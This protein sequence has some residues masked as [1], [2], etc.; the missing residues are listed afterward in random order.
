MTGRVTL[1]WAAGDADGNTL[2]YDVLISRDAGRTFQPLKGEL[3]IRSTQIDTDALGGGSVIFRVVATDGVLT[4][5]SDSPTYSLAAKPPSVQLLTAAGRVKLV[6][7]QNINLIGQARDLQ[8][9][10]VADSGL[11]WTDQKGVVRGRG[12]TL[13]LTQL[14]AGT[15]RMTLTATNSAGLSASASVELVVDDRVEPSGATLDV[16]PGQVRWVV[17]PGAGPQ[18]AR[19]VLGNVGTGSLQWTASTTADWLTLTPAAGSAPETV[20]LTGNPVGLQPGESRTTTLSIRTRDG[21]QTLAVPVSL[22]AEG[23]R[24]EGP[25][26]TITPVP[27]VVG[28]GT[29]DSCTPAALETTLAAASD[30]GKA[31]ITFN[32]GDAPHTLTLPRTLTI[33]SNMIVDGAN[34]ITLNGNGLVRHF[35]LCRPTSNGAD[36]VELELAGLT[37]VNGRSQP[38]RAGG[39]ITNYGCRLTVSH[40]RFVS[41]TAVA[42]AGAINN[43]FD[44]TTTIVESAFIDNRA[45]TT[46]GAIVAREGQLT[47]RNTTF[48]ANVANGGNGGAIFAFDAAPVSILGSTFERNHSVARGGAVSVGGATRIGNSTFSNNT[49]GQGGAAVRHHSKAGL[50]ELVNV[51]ITGDVGQAV[52]GEVT[53]RN[54]VVHNRGGA[55]NCEGTITASGPN[56][57]FPATS[58]GASIQNQ[59]PLL[60]AL[61]DNGGSTQTSALGTTSPA[62]D[63]GD[64]ELC[65]TLGNTDQRGAVRPQ[66]PRCDLGAFEQGAIAP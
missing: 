46:G 20:T 47:V 34:R 37:L 58:C 24:V 29:P 22:Q 39:S 33:G 21:A 57:E 32:C 19:L 15:T 31:R 61:G 18:Q 14:P 41:N 23:P 49:A 30:A 66:G 16:S 60:A 25:P 1:A 28:T 63:A 27:F 13:S 7:G 54:S 52:S 17:K 11:V 48:R 51:T 55:K 36:D 53:L 12:T 43:L 45:A 3:P 4:A 64:N 65:A 62:R 40:T 44:G 38:N 5:K 10:H 26:P 59:D 2:R 35:E 8:D 56:L 9:G 6:F 42:E 50:L